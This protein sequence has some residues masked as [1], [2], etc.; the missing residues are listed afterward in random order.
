MDGCR[1]EKCPM[2]GKRSA[3]SSWRADGVEYWSF[4]CDG[5]QHVWIPKQE[6]G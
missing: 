1:Y 4:Y 2:C 6:E 5:C 3:G